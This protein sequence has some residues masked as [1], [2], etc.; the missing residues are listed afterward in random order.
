MKTMRNNTNITNKEE[1]FQLTPEAI[2]CK[3]GY[4][5]KLSIDEL[6]EISRSQTSEEPQETVR[7]V[8]RTQK[9]KL[10]ESLIETIIEDMIKSH[11]PVTEERYQFVEWLYRIRSHH[12]NHY[13]FL[14][15]DFICIIFGKMMVSKYQRSNTDIRKAVNDWCEDSVKAGRKN[16]VI[17]ASGTHQWLLI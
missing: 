9:K 16:M 13:G 7:G 1:Q 3:R 8:S 6:R 5:E 15:P 17:S 12:G 14:Q 2:D 11:N 4:L 10:K